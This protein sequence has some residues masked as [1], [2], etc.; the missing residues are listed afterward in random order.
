MNNKG[1]SP[2]ATTMET[3]NCYYMSFNHP[4]NQSYFKDSLI[5]TKISVYK[6]QLAVFFT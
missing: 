3:K 1:H 4:M 6:L 2:S 5:R